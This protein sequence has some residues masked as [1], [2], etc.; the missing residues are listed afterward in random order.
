MVSI[1]NDIFHD[2]E[3][4]DLP[5]YIATDSCPFYYQISTKA[6][7][8]KSNSEIDHSES[9]ETTLNMEKI[10]SKDILRYL[11]SMIIVIPNFSLLQ[12][13]P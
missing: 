8:A 11:L 3:V 1:L 9:L 6:R 4:V 7:S 2:P 13:M 5:L 12:N 10:S